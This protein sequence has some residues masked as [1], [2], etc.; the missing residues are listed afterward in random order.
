MTAVRQDVRCKEKQFIGE[1]EQQLWKDD[2]GGY[3]RMQ[4]TF[5]ILHDRN[6]TGY[7]NTRGGRDRQATTSELQWFSNKKECYCK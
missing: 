4:I 5:V 7:E 1:Q 2:G 6:V 3:E